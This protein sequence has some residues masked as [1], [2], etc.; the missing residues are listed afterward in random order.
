MV[1]YAQY[2][3]APQFGNL[4]VNS[5]F[6]KLA[7][8]VNFMHGQPYLGLFEVQQNKLSKQC[9]LDGDSVSHM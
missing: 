4:G 7:V 9:L 8:V 2:V 3:S 6:C 1:P 5:S